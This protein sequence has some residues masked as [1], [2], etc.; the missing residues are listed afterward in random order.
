MSKRT[1]KPR[2]QVD[3]SPTGSVLPCPLCSQRFMRDA[4][5]AAWRALYRHLRG[6]HN[7]ARAA[8]LTQHVRLRIARIN[9]EK[10]QKESTK[11]T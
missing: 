7:E 2:L 3:D 9:W 5:A 11:T 6:H 10:R 1:T 4:P 8:E